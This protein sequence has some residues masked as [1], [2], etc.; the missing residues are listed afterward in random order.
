MDASNPENGAIRTS[1]ERPNSQKLY[2]GPNTQETGIPGIKTSTDSI[3][4]NEEVK[5][6][7]TVD[8][9]GSTIPNEK[10]DGSFPAFEC[11]W[12]YHTLTTN[13]GDWV[14]GCVYDFSKQFNNDNNNLIIYQNLSKLNVPNIQCMTCTEVDRYNSRVSSNDDNDSKTL[15]M[16]AVIPVYIVQPD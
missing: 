3:Y 10:N 13:P 9:S 14:L 1:S 16:S 6:L 12:R 2:W 5:K 8:W 4:I 11:C 7:V 15:Y